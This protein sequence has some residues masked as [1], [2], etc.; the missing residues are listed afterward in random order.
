MGWIECMIVSEIFHSVSAEK[1]DLK[2][3]FFHLSMN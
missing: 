2:T 1:E 3:Y